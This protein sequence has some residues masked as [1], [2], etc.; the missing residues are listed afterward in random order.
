MK[1]CIKEEQARG[2]VQ[3]LSMYFLQQSILAVS[4]NKTRTVKPAV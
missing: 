3:G 4:V 1:C 2:H